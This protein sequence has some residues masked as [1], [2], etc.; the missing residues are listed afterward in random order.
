MRDQFGSDHKNFTLL[1]I[2]HN[3][4]RPRS[5]RISVL[6]VQVAG[7]VAVAALLTLLVFANRYMVMARNMDELIVLRS[8]NAEQLAR[9]QELEQETDELRGRMAELA[10]LDQKVREL[11]DL[12]EAPGVPTAFTARYDENGTLGM[13]GGE[14]VA[15][16][17]APTTQELEQLGRILDQVREEIPYRVASLTQLQG[18]IVARQDAEARTPSIWPVRGVVTSNFGYRRSPFGSAREFHAGYDIAARY[19]TTVVA[20]ARG[21]VVFAGWKLSYGKVVLIDHGNGLRTMYAHNSTLLVEAG[22]KVEKGD[23]IARVGSTGRSTGPHLHYEVLRYGEAIDPGP[24]L[25]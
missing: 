23:P 7:F 22:D 19:G 25:P 20:A 14:E 5:F 16:Q 3:T 10:A 21:R 9:L 18:E 24:Y 2:P 8:T 17:E 4:N 15:P 12:E 11:M 1:I 13:G 6:W